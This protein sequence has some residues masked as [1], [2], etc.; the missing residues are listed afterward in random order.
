MV[1]PRAKKR[2]KTSPTSAITKIIL[3]W[4]LSGIS[5]QLHLAR[6]HR[7][8]QRE[9]FKGLQERHICKTLMGSKS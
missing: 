2:G 9:Q 5:L 1:L 6:V 8:G 7:M 3:V 4:M